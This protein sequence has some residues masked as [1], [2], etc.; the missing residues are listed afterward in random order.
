MRTFCFLLVVGVAFAGPTSKSVSRWKAPG[1]QARLKA[2][3]WQAEKDSSDK[4]PQGRPFLLYVT[5]VASKLSEKI[6]K[7]VLGNTA[8]VLAAAACPWVKLTPGEAADLPFLKTLPRI[9]DPMLVVVDKDAKVVGVL[10]KKRSFSVRRCF[11]LME[12]A[13]DGVYRIRLG[14]Y[15]EEYVKILDATERLLAEQKKLAARERRKKID[16]TEL[17]QRKRELAETDRAL[18][19]QEKTLRASL[20]VK[21]DAD[22]EEANEEAPSK[23]SAAEREALRAYRKQ[24]RHKSPIVRANSLQ[25]LR[26]IDTP[27]MVRQVLAA[28]RHGDSWTVWRA[29]QLLA[30]MNSDSCWK[31]IVRA[32]EKGGNR[33]RRAALLSLEGR[34]HAMAWPHILKLAKSRIYEIRSAAVRALAGQEDNSCLS[35][36]LSALKDD[37]PRIRALA[38]RGVR[39]AAPLHDML[40]DKD[41]SVRRAAVHALAAARSP[42]SV[43]HLL[44]RFQKESGVLRD[45][46]HAALVTLTAKTFFYDQDA[47]QQWWKQAG[48]KFTLSSNK[49]VE[50]ALER[51][52]K[53]GDNEAWTFSCRYHSVRTGSRRLIFLLDVGPSMAQMIDLP[54][55]ASAR[56]KKDLRSGTKLDLAKRELIRALNQLERN[57]EFNI[58]VYAGGVRTWRRHLTK[59][60]HRPSA[61]E[62]IKR[63]QVVH[64]G[65]RAPSSVGAGGPRANSAEMHVIP[66][67]TRAG[68]TAPVGAEHK[69]DVFGAL[70]IGL[71]VFGKEP[72]IDRRR[73]EADTVFLVVDGAPSIGQV[74]DVPQIA[75]ILAELNL[76]RR[77][78]LHV[79][80]F[81]TRTR[82]VYKP[83]VQVMGGRIAVHG[84]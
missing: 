40:E 83:L 5:E 21:K 16:A 79:V 11:A 18:R 70:L 8:I 84:Q 81:H 39:S 29:G 51:V 56:Q 71:G 27:A 62:F 3:W 13:A 37:D 20:G 63:L 55:G 49:S 78:T 23:L 53:A 19:L 48:P 60:S 17:A 22:Q 41:W 59:A 46:C 82:E 80:T 74:T 61:I 65:K 73:P 33:E 58:I 6:E 30:R 52:T 26:N 43:P 36:L 35:R 42:E 2:V 25:A 34:N 10:D 75:E 76:T 31:L 57:D 12:R 4:T 72:L 44:F 32:L 28:A 47:W 68:K 45:D 24:A 69:R 38:A 77:I 1:N 7:D 9:A 64:Q 67:R 50:A 66:G 54:M 15:V 14:K